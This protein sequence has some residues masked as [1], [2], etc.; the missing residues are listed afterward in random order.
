MRKR[1]ALLAGIA[2]GLTSQLMAQSPVLSGIESPYP[3]LQSSAVIHIAG[4][5]YG[6]G[7][8]PYGPHGTPLIL[9]GVNFGSDG[10][11][12]FVGYKNGAVDPGTTVQATVT[13][14]DPSILMITVPSSA[15]TGLVF[16][17]SGGKTSNG[18]PFIVTQGTYSGTC[19]QFPPSSQL[20]ITTASLPNGLVGQSYS[21]TLNA[22][23]GTPPYTWAMTGN[24][25]PSGLS[26][27]PSAG[28][29]TGSPTAVQ[30]PFDVTANATDSRGQTTDAVLS[31]TIE[32]RP[33]SSG[34]VY[35]YSVPSS[36][37]F[38]GV[39]N[40]TQYVDSV[41][42]TWN[43]AFDN[44]NRLSSAV[45]GTGASSAYQGQDLCYN[46]DAFG[47]RT[48]AGFQTS[49][50]SSSNPPTA[51]YNTANQM[52]GLSYDAAGNVIYDGTN[53]YSYDGD[54]RLCAMQTSSP[55][56]V[57]AYGYVYD[58]EG[59][60][61]ARG[62]I[63]PS[64]LGQQPSCN[65]SANGFALTESYVV[66]Q[67]GEELTMLDGS[68]HWE[69]TNVYGGGK[70]LATYDTAGLHFHVADP[71]GTRRVQANAQG[72]TEEDCQNLPFGDQQICN[73]TDATPLHFTGKERDPESGND[74]F[75]ARYYASGMG[76]FLS[77]DWSATVSPVPYASLADPQSLNLYVYVMN[78]PLTHMDASGHYGQDSCVTSFCVGSSHGGP[79]S[80]INSMKADMNFNFTWELDTFV[81]ITGS[82]Q[83]QTASEI[84][85]KVGK[86]LSTATKWFNR[87]DTTKVIFDDVQERQAWNRIL[88]A[89]N[90]ALQRDTNPNL[91]GAQGNVEVDN[92]LKGLAEAQIQ[93]LST[94]MGINANGLLSSFD[95]S[96]S[97]ASK[98]LPTLQQTVTEAQQRYDEAVK[99]W[100]AGLTRQASSSTTIN[101]Q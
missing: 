46:Y 89:A 21:A 38:D 39:G 53:Y 88:T 5:T 29:I 82:S 8:V 60:R 18:L 12:E 59:N 27:A 93:Y 84:G 61:V 35:S 13:N 90:N 48:Q 71:L 45:P 44:L 34:V 100:A 64:A 22:Q 51:S 32:S 87:A 99:S 98:L 16:V 30:G 56:G 81:A 36:G 101:P 62:T 49:A 74:Y 96:T 24:A 97:F 25:L 79:G 40:I 73:G 54:G 26:L 2:L 10:I 95:P 28:A 33:E 80:L 19:P 86:Y 37:G 66:G 43:F 7:A 47:N 11:V 31:I 4:G 83:Q 42:G 23:G 3:A 91:S 15:V 41:Q 20:Q 63:N 55:V 50:C 92:A 75:G 78:N 94:K 6:S 69:R 65:L 76:R 70:L 14:W 77:P 1:F 52:S 58:A 67:S 72:E 68:S 17:S 85:S 9:S 57:L